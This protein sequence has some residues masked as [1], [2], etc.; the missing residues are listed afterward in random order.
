VTLDGETRLLDSG[1]I[2][3]V[4]AG[5]VHSGKALTRVRAVDAF[6]PIREDYR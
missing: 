4:P 3:V 5:T 6:H 1:T 2:A